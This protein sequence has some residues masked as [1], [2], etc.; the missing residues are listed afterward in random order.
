MEDL[1]LLVTDYLRSP[2]FLRVWA[3]TLGRHPLGPLFRWASKDRPMACTV[4]SSAALALSE[5]RFVKEAVDMT[6]SRKLVDLGT[7]C[8]VTSYE[9]VAAGPAVLAILA[10]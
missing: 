9:G 8:A 2:L 10:L 1:A 4:E 7:L 5:D 3:S 6:D